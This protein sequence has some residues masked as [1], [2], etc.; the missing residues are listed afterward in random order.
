MEIGLQPENVER[1]FSAFFTSKSQGTGMGLP[2]SRSIIES[3]GGTVENNGTTVVHQR[4][5]LLNGEVDT[6]RVG[7]ERLV[8]MLQ[9]C[10]FTSLVC[11]SSTN[12]VLAKTISILR[13][14]AATVL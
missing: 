2:I 1:I 13:F 5:R 14:C 11:L 9:C 7:I 12:P 3:H 10:G 8:E 6:T 4:Q